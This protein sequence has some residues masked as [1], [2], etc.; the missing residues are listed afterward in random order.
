MKPKTSQSTAGKRQP[1]KKPFWD[2]WDCDRC[3]SSA[4]DT[5][6]R[7][8]VA[9]YEEIHF[10]GFQAASLSNILER[11]GVTKGALYH[12]FPSKKALGYAV[13]DELIAA[14]MKEHW[15]APLQQ[16]NPIDALILEIQTSGKQ[17]TLDD[18]KLGCPLNNLAQ[19][20]APVDEDF[21]QRIDR[22]Y[23]EWR[24]GI[25]RELKRGQ[26]AGLV[27][28][29]IDTEGMATLIVASLEG[30]IGLAK[31]SQRMGVLKSCGQSLINIID[32]LRTCPSNRKEKP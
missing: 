6:E 15:I 27:R 17:M 5:R 31:T 30:C 32:N 22:I 28:E 25:S 13:I 29:D 4:E 16:D 21:R 8:L 3:N 20:M 2:F 7:L 9:A 26:A 1:K 24:S 19:E 14:S 23:K 18:I 10:A 11:T 12:H